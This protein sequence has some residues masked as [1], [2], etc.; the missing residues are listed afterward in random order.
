MGEL[1]LVTGG[2]GFLGQVLVNFLLQR[3]DGVRVISR[4]D[5]P[6]L[7]AMGA[8]T[9]Q[10]DIRDIG[11]MTRACAGVDVVHHVAALPG[12][13]G[14]ES[15]FR[16]INV[17]GTDT[18]IAACRKN[19]V[20]RLV[21]TSSPSVIYSGGDIRGESESELPYP[22]RHNCIY[23]RT[24]A[25]AERRVLASDRTPLEGGLMFR[26][27]ALR[28]HLIW[29]PGDRNLIP[30]LIEK[31]RN[32][33]LR[34]VGSGDNMVDVVYV[35]N[36]ARA[37]ITAA[38]ALKSRPD[39]ISGKAYFITQ[40]KPVKLWDFINEILGMAQVPQVRSHISYN[41]AW[42]AGAIMEVGHTLTGSQREPRMTRFLAQQLAKDHFFDIMAAKMELGYVPEISTDEGLKRLEIWLH[43]SGIASGEESSR[44]KS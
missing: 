6:A 17:D 35:D 32:G 28:P 25:I 9:L 43:E 4:G 39:R 27:V 26:T 24:K 11:D 15:D 33:Q 38:D 8:Q 7:R 22:V 1:A 19:R 30:R 40:Q 14:L 41:L 10:G 16:S 2:G 21:Y 23:P 3:G 31:A 20:T 13:W 12:I 37:Q 18:V 44:D 34:I 42:L 29:G 36:A 5:Y